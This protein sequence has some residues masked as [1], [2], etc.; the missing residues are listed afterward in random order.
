[1]RLQILSA[2][3]LDGTVI[4]NNI[5]MKN[6]KIFRYF[7]I[8]FIVIVFIFLFTQK[9][10]QKNDKEALNNIQY[11]K[12]AGQIIKVNLALTPKEQER[13]LSGRN[14]LKEDEGMLFVFDNMDKHYFWMKD[15][16]FPIDIIWIDEDLYVIFIEKNIQIESY[17]ETF[18][19]N[20][21]SKYVLEVNA[22][23]SEKNN[24]KEG[25]KIEFLP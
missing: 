5:F 19:S 20:K 22:S 2:S 25:E 15:M 3:F 13:G 16:N 8:V 12:I 24:L 9:T 21:D 7:V 6:K 14:N 23:F 10:N 17:P 18:G 1:M 4:Q 11:I